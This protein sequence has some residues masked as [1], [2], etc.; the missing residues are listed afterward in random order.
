MRRV[1]GIPRPLALMLVVA[2]SL[3]IAW[4]VAT[5]ALQGPDE[6]RHFAYLQYL[7]ETGHL[8]RATTGNEALEVAPGSIEEQ[9]A[10]NTLD[11]RA[12]LTN[13]RRQLDR[14]CWKALVIT[15]RQRTDDRI[16]LAFKMGDVGDFAT[17]MRFKFSFA[18]SVVMLLLRGG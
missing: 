15:K 4:D 18:A 14:L 10:M 12:T 1:R 9:D 3:S 2:A 16:R 17:Q 6:A 5:P 13:R 11:L 7:A 8:P